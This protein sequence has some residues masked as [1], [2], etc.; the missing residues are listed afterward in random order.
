ML[1]VGPSR[2]LDRGA[3]ARTS[4]APTP[5]GH[6]RRACVVQRGGDMARCDGGERASPPGQTKTMAAQLDPTEGDGSGRVDC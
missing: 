6:S 5:R 1:A 4:A 2:L 3:I